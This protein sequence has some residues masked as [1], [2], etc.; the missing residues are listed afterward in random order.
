MI[1]T[2]Y[3]HIL[4]SRHFAEMQGVKALYLAA[5]NTF[6]SFPYA[7]VREFIALILENRNW[8]L[9]MMVIVLLYEMVSLPWQV[10]W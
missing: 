6:I 8:T 9:S 4:R 2:N 5:K 3:Y 10:R 7:T 1:V